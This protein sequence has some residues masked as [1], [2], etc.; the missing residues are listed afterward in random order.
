MTK[1][2]D[3]SSFQYRPLPG[4]PLLQCARCGASYLDDKPSREAHRTVFGHLP[5]APKRERE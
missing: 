2:Q 4:T 3:W 1:P 5:P